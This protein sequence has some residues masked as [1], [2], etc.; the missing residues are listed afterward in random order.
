[1]GRCWGKRS[2]AG[3][4]GSSVAS[5]YNMKRAR[6]WLSS[7]STRMKVCRSGGVVSSKNTR[8]VAAND[9]RTHVAWMRRV[10]GVRGAVK[11]SES[12]EVEVTYTES[13]WIIFGEPAGVRRGV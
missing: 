12:R 3:G 9:R 8:R 10:R 4:A 5:W 2:P 1:M 6:A 7:G 11:S 13:A